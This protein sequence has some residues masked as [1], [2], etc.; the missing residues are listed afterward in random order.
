MYKTVFDISLLLADLFTYVLLI[1]SLVWCFKGFN[2]PYVK[3]LPIYCLGN[4]LATSL[5]LIMPNWYQTTTAIFTVFELL[6]FGYFLQQLVRSR[7]M[8]RI[9]WTLIA[10]YLLRVMIGI[11]RN[12]VQKVGILV[13]LECVILIPPCLVYLREVFLAPAIA[14]LET[15]PAFWMVSGILFYF[16]LLIPALVVSSYYYQHGELVLAT[17]FYSVNNYS[18]IISYCLF[19]K[20]MTCRKKL[21]L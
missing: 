20:A 16:V 15:V 6:F 9:L 5:N 13:V 8:K 17:L 2:P 10:L 1:F 11:I 18:E 4:A 12:E 7:L 3:L 21:L 14:D 19:L